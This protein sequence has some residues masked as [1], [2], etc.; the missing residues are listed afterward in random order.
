MRFLDGLVEEDEYN[1]FERVFMVKKNKLKILVGVI[2]VGAGLIV[3]LSM[4]EAKLDKNLPRNQA[5]WEDKYP[6]V[7]SNVGYAKLIESAPEV[8]QYSKLPES[9]QELSGK[10]TNR[11]GIR[12]DIL[13]FIIQK[14]SESTDERIFRA[15]I[16]YAQDMQQIYYGNVGQE[17]AV[18]L[19]RRDSLLLGC[20]HDY[21]DN[22]EITRG[23]SK[24]MRD[25]KPRNQHMWRLDQEYFSWQ[26]LGSGLSSADEDKFC[27]EGVF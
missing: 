10:I 3:W 24:R 8:T 22:F 21:T 20:L 2:V 14:A 6:Q 9:L 27:K 4:G 19:S 5:Q 11:F 7:F 18:R 17:E 12:D 15:A 25:S 26:L 23:L 13:E 16:L 1:N